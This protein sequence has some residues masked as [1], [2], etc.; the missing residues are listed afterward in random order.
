MSLDTPSGSS[1]VSSAGPA[2]SH[3][4]SHPSISSHNSA[5]YL[6]DFQTPKTVSIHACCNVRRNDSSSMKFQ[7]GKHSIQAMCLCTAHE[8]WC[9]C[10]MVFTNLKFSENTPGIV[11]AKYVWIYGKGDKL[12]LEEGGKLRLKP[13]YLSPFDTPQCWDNIWAHSRDLQQNTL[14]WFKNCHWQL[15]GEKI[16]LWWSPCQLVMGGPL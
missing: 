11:R 4:N 15:C 9:F 7:H 13:P 6:S 3:R 8:Q 10:F 2:Q 14:L 12:N 1:S 16:L 5:R